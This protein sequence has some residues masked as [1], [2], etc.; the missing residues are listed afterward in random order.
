[1]RQRSTLITRRFRR[2]FCRTMRLK[3]NWSGRSPCI[4]GGWAGCSVSRRRCSTPR[5]VVST[6]TALFIPVHP[7]CA[8]A[9]RR[10]PISG[11]SGSRNW[12][13]EKPRST[14]LWRAPSLCWSAVRPRAAATKKF[15]KTKPIYRAESTAAAEKRS[16]NEGNIVDHKPKTY[17]SVVR[18]QISLPREYSVYEKDKDDRI[19]KNKSALSN[20]LNVKTVLFQSSRGKSSLTM[21]YEILIP[22]EEFRIFV[23]RIASFTLID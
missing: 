2:H 6:V 14:A 19:N 22:C 15:P 23:T 11:R 12:R 5:R 16:Q 17:L 18:F 3:R 8:P 21:E 1:M 9:A 10:R 4:N 13:A 20:I 7:R